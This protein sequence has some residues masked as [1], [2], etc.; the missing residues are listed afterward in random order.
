MSENTS[1]TASKYQNK[2]KYGKET[3]GAV[4]FPYF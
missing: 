4:S 2:Y 3:A 1:L